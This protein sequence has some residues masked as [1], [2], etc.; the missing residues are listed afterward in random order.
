MCVRG[1][2]VAGKS[3]GEG[4]SAYE[5]GEVVCCKPWLDEL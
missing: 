5:G 2:A 1:I 4:E 3:V